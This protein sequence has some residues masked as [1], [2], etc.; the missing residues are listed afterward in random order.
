MH[1]NIKRSDGALLV[2]RTLGGCGRSIAPKQDRST[3]DITIVDDRG[4]WRPTDLAHCDNPLFCDACAPNR[5]A[6][7]RARWLWHFTTWEREGG[8]LLAITLTLPHRRGD[9]LA[10]LHKA[11]NSCFTKLRDSAAWRHAGIVDWVRVLH[12]RWSPDHGWH[13]HYHVTAFVHPARGAITPEVIAALQASW[14]QRTAK[15]GFTRLRGH[16][17][18][19]A[20]TAATGLRRLYAWTTWAEPDDDQWGTDDWETDDWEPEHDATLNMRQLATR[21]LNGD[22]SAWA[23]WAEATLALKGAKVTRCSRRLD[24][25]WRDF[26]PDTEDTL[27]PADNAPKVARVAGSLWEVARRADVAE[28]GVAYGQAHGIDAWRAWW[29]DQLGRPVTVNYAFS[30]PRLALKEPPPKGTNRDRLPALRRQPGREPHPGR[31]LRTGRP[32]PAERR[33]H[34]G[35]RPWPPRPPAT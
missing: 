1:G 7:A 11:L 29:Q 33:H 26:G 32:E 12:L 21:A 10:T 13:L 9:G 34:R 20:R 31:H 25:I 28:A 14:R 5:E 16:R 22:T 17:G 27:E 30:P 3:S 15:A 19:V 24:R 2:H 6:E 18:L 35:D 4:T 8:H 23:A